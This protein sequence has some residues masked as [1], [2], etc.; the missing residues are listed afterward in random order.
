MTTEYIS[1]TTISK[2]NDYIKTIPESIMQNWQKK[3]QQVYAAIV[4]VQTKR[5]LDYVPGV[6]VEVSLPTGSLC[7]ERSAIASAVAKYPYIEHKD[8]IEFYVKQIYPENKKAEPCGV[9]KEWISKIFY[10]NNFQ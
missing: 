6:N 4:V 5:G 10:K 8:F 1:P 9:C 2:L 7:A 3:S